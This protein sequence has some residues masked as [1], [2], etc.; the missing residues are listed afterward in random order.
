MTF[1]ENLRVIR[2][3]RGYTQKQIAEVLETTQQYYS[4]YENGKRD[5]PIRIY[6]TLSKFYNVT[7]DYLA[8]QSDSAEPLS[9][10]REKADAG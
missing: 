2:E 6:I 9:G 1:Y 4:D 7:I 8:G 3:D 10:S 5:I